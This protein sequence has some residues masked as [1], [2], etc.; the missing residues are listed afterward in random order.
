M[1]VKDD[2]FQ[3]YFDGASRGNPGMGGY[4][5]AIFSND[6]EIKTYSKFIDKSVTN[7]E[8]EYQGCLK[9]LKY[10]YKHKLNNVI[11]KGDS[12][13]VIKQMNGEWK[14]KAKNLIPIY[15]KCLKYRNRLSKVVFIHVPRKENSRADELANIAL[16]EN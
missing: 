3:I 7:N 16:D 2:I 6:E 12:N 5:V 10:A 9:C 8:A 1:E 11:I 13:L 4:G 14:C 15:E